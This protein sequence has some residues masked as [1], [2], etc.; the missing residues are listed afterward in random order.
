MGITS[1]SLELIERALQ[2]IPVKN[3]MELGAQNLYDKEYPSRVSKGQPYASE[4]YL[5]K[6]IEYSCIDL[7]GENNALQID[8]EKKYKPEKQFDLVTDFGTGEHIRKAYNVFKILH[9]LTKYGG[10][11]I[12]QNPKTENW[13]EHG[14]WYT[15]QEMYKQ[16]A[17][18]QG[19]QI[20]ELG[21]DA[22][23][24]NISDGWNV[25]CIYIKSNDIPFMPKIK[26]K[27]DI[28]ILSK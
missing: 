6:G 1:T 7:N 19:Y 16:L 2:V 15:T 12:R 26:F 9:D 14:F 23:M 11:I 21:E 5:A 27:H 8:L 4:Y 17:K 18:S 25:Y 24:G 28:T 10:I 3:V 20:I 13:K 22:A